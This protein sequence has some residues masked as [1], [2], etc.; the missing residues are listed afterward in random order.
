M[1]NDTKR[2][3]RHIWDTGKAAGKQVD[4]RKWV[5][6][7]KIY[8]YCIWK[9]MSCKSAEKKKVSGRG[10]EQTTNL[11]E[12][13]SSGRIIKSESQQTYPCLSF[14]FILLCSS[15]LSAMSHLS[16]PVKSPPPPIPLNFLH[17]L[18]QFFYSLLT[19]SFLLQGSYFLLFF[20][21]STGVR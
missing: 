12:T 5:N 10:A 7:K 16:T 15:S 21:L 2:G 13:I 8:I 9:V 1:K 18:Q 6:E 17:F 19:L 3:H 4:A 14:S 11:N 20:S